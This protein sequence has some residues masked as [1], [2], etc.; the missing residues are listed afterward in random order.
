MLRFMLFLFHGCCVDSAHWDGTITLPREVYLL[1]FLVLNPF[2]LSQSPSISLPNNKY[3]ENFSFHDSHSDHII[4]SAI[5]ACVSKINQLL[6]QG[7]EKN[8]NQDI[9]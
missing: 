9:S 4:E 7:L 3:L 8:K 6:N 5:K 2:S 1:L